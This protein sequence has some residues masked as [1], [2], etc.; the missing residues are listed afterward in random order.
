[1]RFRLRSLVIATIFLPP[2]LASGWRFVEA[3]LTPME[4]VIPGAHEVRSDSWKRATMEVER[5][6]ALKVGLRCE[7]AP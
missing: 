4:A 3:A 6:E 2:L 1:M 7:E 5:L